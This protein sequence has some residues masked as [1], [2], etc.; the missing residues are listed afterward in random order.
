MIPCN[1]NDIPGYI[2]TQPKANQ[3]YYSVTKRLSYYWDE[4]EPN[5]YPTTLA[6]AILTDLLEIKGVTNCP[7]IGG[8]GPSGGGGDTTKIVIYELVSCTDENDKIYTSLSIGSINQI[9][10]LFLN[11]GNKSYQYRGNSTLIDRNQAPPL[12]NVFIDL[13][14]FNC[15]TTET[16]G[17][18]GGSGGQDTSSIDLTR[19]IPGNTIDFLSY[20]NIGNNTGGDN[21][22]GGGTGGGSTGGGGPIP[23]MRT[24]G[25]STGGSSGTGGSRGNP[26]YDPFS[27]KNN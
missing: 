27:R 5:F 8:G 1:S 19:G 14:N 6:I 3:I 22:G 17:G 4:L 13:N 11:S 21:T 18:G 23:F 26:P 12:V 20:Q 25:R 24:N 10:T 2:A 16:P 9:C 7:G 15:P